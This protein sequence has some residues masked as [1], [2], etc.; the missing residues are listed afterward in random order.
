MKELNEH[1]QLRA[2]RYAT[3]T[4]KQP[5]DTC[6]SRGDVS[7]QQRD[8]EGT[9]RIAVQKG[10]RKLGGT[11]VAVSLS[12]YVADFCMQ[13]DWVASPISHRRDGRSP[14]EARSRSQWLYVLRLIR[15]SSPSRIWNVRVGSRTT[16]ASRW[17]DAAA[18]MSKPQMCEELTNVVSKFMRRL[19]RP[20]E[21][22][23]GMLRL[24]NIQSGELLLTTG[25]R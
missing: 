3:H 13:A 9:T 25:A 23:I 10:D 16:A 4:T 21:Y 1:S 22:A 15:N 17:R 8:M 7:G 24:V 6:E 19:R 14:L 18:V 5:L 12:T 20:S 2:T 11:H